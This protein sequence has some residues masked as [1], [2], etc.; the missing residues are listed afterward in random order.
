M[1]FKSVYSP[2]D[3]MNKCKTILF[4]AYIEC[5]DHDT[6]KKTPLYYGV[7][8]QVRIKDY[9]FYQLQGNLLIY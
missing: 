2:E 3:R 8:I 1:D 5:I 4:Y 6:G 9:I 7:Q